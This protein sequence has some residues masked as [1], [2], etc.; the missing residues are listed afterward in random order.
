[1]TYGNEQLLDALEKNPLMA[2]MPAV[3]NRALVTLGRDP[4]GTAA[5]PTPLSIS[6]VLKDYV[7]V[8]AEAARK[9]R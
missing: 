3:A 9:S 7:A 2:R 4:L 5:N 1:M 8:L 6:W